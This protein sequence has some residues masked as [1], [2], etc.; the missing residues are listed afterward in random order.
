[1]L[2]NRVAHRARDL[3]A[4]VSASQLVFDLEVHER[5][6][7]AHGARALDVCR[8]SRQSTSAVA[9]QRGA[10]AAAIAVDSAGSEALVT[11]IWTPESFRPVWLSQE[12]PWN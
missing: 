4:L 10:S 6:A 7:G 11:T 3:G 5:E 8:S 9:C 2:R 1:V 12:K